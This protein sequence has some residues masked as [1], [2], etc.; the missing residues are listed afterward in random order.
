LYTKANDCERAV[1]ALESKKINIG[2]DD[3]INIGANAS[4]EG[5]D[6]EE[7]DASEVK[8]EINIVHAHQ[9]QKQELD[10]KTYKTMQKKYWKDLKQKIESMRYKILG[11]GED[12]KAPADKKEA[13]AKEDAAISKLS[14]SDKVEFKVVQSRFDAFKKNWEGLQK[15]VADE[16]EKNFN[17]YEFYLPAETDLGSGMIIPARYVGEALSPT[18][19]YY[20]CGLVEEK[21]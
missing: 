3:N 19:Y 12:Y 20:Q 1:L 15:F 13:K 8:Q 9:L 6:A 17:E 11:L 2:G 10:L 16:I 5:E 7:V 21:Q 4:A 14:K 18:F